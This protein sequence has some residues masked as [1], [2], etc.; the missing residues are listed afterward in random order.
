[1]FLK[2]KIKWNPRERVTMRT[3]LSDVKK[4]VSMK[5]GVNGNHSVTVTG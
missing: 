4:A 3:K 1:M 5:V 2:V